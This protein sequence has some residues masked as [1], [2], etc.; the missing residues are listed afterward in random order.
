ML[1]KEPSRNE[2]TAPLNFESQERGSE[3]RISPKKGNFNSY[4]LRAFSITS[5][6]MACTWK[7]ILFRKGLEGEKERRREKIS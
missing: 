5:I 4:S 1:R 2:P 7:R 3:F 6:G